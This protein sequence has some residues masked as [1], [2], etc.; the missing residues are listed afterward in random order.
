MSDA[1]LSQPDAVGK[2][3]A[4]VIDGVGSAIKAEGSKVLW[5]IVC[6]F[7]ALMVKAW[8]EYE[9]YIELRADVAAIM[10]RVER[11]ENKITTD[12]DRITSLEARRST[13]STKISSPFEP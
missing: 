8:L 10:K 7:C 6:L 2:A 1:N 4:P 9:K 13:V 12:H 3:L 5:A 11:I